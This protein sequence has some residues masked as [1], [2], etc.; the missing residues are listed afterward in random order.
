MSD[1]VFFIQI[2]FNKCA[3]SAFAKLFQ[4][5]G[6]KALHSGGRIWRL[7]GHPAITEIAP[8]RRIAQNIDAGRPPLAGL[9]E[10][11][12]FFDM[13]AFTDANAT[14]RE[15]HKRFDLFAEAYPNAKFLLNTRDEDDWLRSRL[16]HDDGQFAKNWMAAAGIDQDGLIRTWRQEFRD[17]HARVRA[18]FADRPGR[19]LEFDTG[20]DD[21]ARLIDFARPDFTLNPKRWRRVRV[22]DEVA[23]RKGWRG[24]GD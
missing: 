21:V 10:F 7:Q 6:Y 17:H 16:R 9:E 2:G 12:A 19:C 14:P 3:T 1:K 5:S 11:D 8:Q 23:R 4:G 24:P 20:H 13:I 15:H 22:T 18:Y